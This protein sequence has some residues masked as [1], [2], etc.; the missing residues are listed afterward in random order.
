MDLPV[1]MAIHVQGLSTPERLG[2]A[3]GMPP[4]DA[5]TRA[6][7]MVDAGFA[8][9][10]DGAFELTAGGLDELDEAL[11]REG[12]YADDTLSELAARFAPL[13]ER[14]EELASRWRIRRHGTAEVDNDHA[15]AD[16]DQACFD[17]IGELYDRAS[18]VLLRMTDR[19]SRLGCYRGRMEACVERLRAGDTTAFDTPHSE[20]VV[21]VWRELRRDLTRTL[22]GEDG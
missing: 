10:R 22:T 11:D 13:D 19:C 5:V 4:D 14:L 6:G 3:L 21:A 8:E 12:F 15:D 2:L 20:S 17:A 1:L 18:P 7:R 9:L 16:Y